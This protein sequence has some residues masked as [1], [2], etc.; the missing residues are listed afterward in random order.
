MMMSFS[1]DCLYHQRRLLLSLLL[2][3][4][5]TSSASK[6]LGDFASP[7]WSVP[8]TPKHTLLRSIAAISSHDLGLF[9]LP[10]H[11]ALINVA[12]EVTG[13][14]RGG[15][16]DDHLSSWP[17][18]TQ[19]TSG[20]SWPWLDQVSINNNSRCAFCRIQF[21][22]STSTLAH[23]PSNLCCHPKS[24]SIP[25]LRANTYQVT[26]SMLFRKSSQLYKTPNF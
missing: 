5:A 23:T 10:P 13:V 9:A 1:A 24:N 16:L 21:F 3:L 4:S 7:L 19:E 14:P 25:R 18:F 12:S 11:T 2:L 22:V 8:P 15:G 17:T 20:S 6:Q 26:L